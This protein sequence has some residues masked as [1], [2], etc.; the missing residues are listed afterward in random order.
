MNICLA[1]VLDA[2]ALQ[3]VRAALM[4]ASFADGASTAGWHASKVKHN[5]QATHDAAAQRVHQALMRHPLFR[6]A[7]LPSKLRTPLFSRYLPGMSY[8][9]HVD[10][11]MMGGAMPLR[12]DIAITVF[13]SDPASYDG[14]ELIIESHSGD[15]R[16]KLDAG[17][18]IVYPATT[19]HQVAPVTRGERLAAVLWVQSLVREPS[20][21]EILFDIDTARRM[22][23]EKA[24]KQ[25]TPEFD[26]LSKSYA[27]LVRSWSEP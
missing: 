12:T 20:R 11:A 23:W 7:V 14:G 16:Y 2:D 27:N 1:G 25:A 8:G 15:T 9:R 3:A 6:S 4:H 26:L 10:D 21:R 22:L 17:Q 13:L 5:L 24:G 18:A 19:I